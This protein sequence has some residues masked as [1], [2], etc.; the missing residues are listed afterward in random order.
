M[1]FNEYLD[2]IKE[3]TREFEYNNAICTIYIESAY[4]DYKHDLADAELTFL[5]TGA[6]K[7]E[8]D[9]KASDKFKEKAQK[10]VNEL[11]DGIV[12]F[13]NDTKKH[14]DSFNDS[15]NTKKVLELVKS[16][17]KVTKINVVSYTQSLNAIKAIEVYLIKNLTFLKTG[18]TAGVSTDKFNNEVS[19]YNK[20]LKEA[21]ASIDVDLN[22]A[23]SMYNAAVKDL[24]KV[25][26]SVNQINKFKDFA[27][28]SGKPEVVELYIK[29]L[30]E[31]ISVEKDK[32][33][34]INISVENIISSMKSALNGS[35]NS[36]KD[37]KE[38]TKQEEK[39]EDI[40]KESEDIDFGEFI[41]DILESV[42]LSDEEAVTETFM[43]KAN[44]DAK[45]V[46][47]ETNVNVK[48]A[49]K[50]FRNA[51][52]KDDYISAKRIADNIIAYYDASIEYLM[53]QKN[54]TKD[55]ENGVQ[56]QKAKDGWTC[57]FVTL[58]TFGLKTPKYKAVLRSIDE[59]TK[60]LHDSTNKDDLDA[61][62]FNTYKN[63]LIAILRG[64][65]SEAMRL[66]DIIDTNK[67]QYDKRI[68]KISKKEEKQAAKYNKA[69]DKA[70][71]L[72]GESSDITLDDIVRDIN[73]NELTLESL[74]SD[75]A[76]ASEMSDKDMSKAIDNV[77]KDIEKDSKD[78]SDKPASTE[79][80]NMN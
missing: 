62:K 35:D 6:N 26:A 63:R 51:V 36:S 38:N 11:V 66:Y 17:K 14:L 59:L 78:I 9:A 18:I 58:G 56:V 10:S 41:D 48:A 61:S 77:S 53:N 8:L 70:K 46:F 47:D 19:K 43:T 49:H 30:S 32:I 79:S 25:V 4:K 16:S 75:I 20:A 2:A 31:Y 3:S 65:R 12:T 54:T 76:K 24:A 60:E 5:E 13:A 34:R 52:K 69:E 1:T 57:L 80:N 7:D 23:V 29:Y 64:G 68:A 50:D 71:K 22:K 37:A 39:K 42:E 33:R 45:K 44:K 67:L 72:V 73:S 21:N 74:E 15:D 55:A 40:K 28:I 27:K